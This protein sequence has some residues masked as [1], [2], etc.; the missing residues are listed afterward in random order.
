MGGLND[1]RMADCLVTFSAQSMSFADVC[2]GPAS[3]VL[4]MV[5][6]S[7]WCLLGDLSGSSA[8][9]PGKGPK[10]REA[11]WTKLRVKSA[12]DVRTMDHRLVTWA[13]IIFSQVWKL[14]AND[15]GS[16][17]FCFLMSILFLACRWLPSCCILVW[18]FLWAGGE[19]EEEISARSFSLLPLPLL[20]KDTTT[21][22][23]GLHPY[24]LI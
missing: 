4:R 5:W 7:G 19:T 2:V 9:K 22:G 17:W 12:Q 1:T 15:Q 24:D 16:G 13:T 21:V 10:S 3:E 18:P 11:G 6:W 14:E 20:I 8:S 23:L